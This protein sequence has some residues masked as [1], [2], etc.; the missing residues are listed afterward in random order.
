MP[1][2]C[3]WRP[4]SLSDTRMPM[5]LRTSAR[6]TCTSA[7]ASTP[8]ATITAAT[9]ACSASTRTA[10]SGTSSRSAAAMA[11]RCRV[12]PRRARSSAPALRPTRSRMRST[13]CWRPSS[14]SA[15]RASA[16]SMPS[17]AWAWT[18]SRRPPTP[19]ASPLPGLKHEVHQP[20]HLPLEARHRRRRPQARPGPC[21]APAAD[22]GAMACRARPLAA[23]RAGCDR[24]PER[25]RH[26]P[27]RARPASH[28][29]G[30]ARLPQ[31]DRWPRL[32]P[33]PSA[34]HPPQVHRRHPRDRP[35]PGGHD[36]AARPHRL[37]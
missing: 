17:S 20:H 24:I 22:A 36:A 4:R 5:S 30:R 9:S 6:S 18:P 15:R 19:C 29:P 2:R 28:C 32:Q 26:P 21:A 1:A 16:S 31:V 13:R 8:A 23:R 14:A 3:R 25:R 10:P 34:A 33:G 35:G 27:T 12:P 11:P 37:R 7:A